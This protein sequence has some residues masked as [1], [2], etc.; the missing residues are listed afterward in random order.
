LAARAKK[1]ER[2]LAIGH[3]LR[4]SSLWGGVKDLI[5]RGL[6][7]SPQYVLVELSRRPYREGAQKWRFD[8]ERVG[9]WI[10]EEP[11]HFFDLA[12]WYLSNAGEPETVYAAAN[13]RD[14]SRPQLHDNFSAIMKY[15]GGQFAM[16]AQ[17]L[18]AFEHHQTVKVAGTRGAL[19]ARWSGA[20]DRT[21]HPT[22]SLRAFDGEQITDVP[23]EK[24]TGEA[25]E[26]EDQIA[27]MV[28]SVRESK[29]LLPGA[30]DGIRSVALCLA[31]A[32]SVKSGR[33]VNMSEVLQR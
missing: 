23:I 29:L 27:L 19:W 21:L 14:F 11:I 17:T 15:A 24:I 13:S 16:I 3:E 1:R 5:D 6:I 32:E 10:L 12:R 28:R 25:F 18:S 20:M 33:V 30:D 4:Q 31:A 22:F 26:L 9:N 8:H 2:L 7:G